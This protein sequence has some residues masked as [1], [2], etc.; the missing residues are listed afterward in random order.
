MKVCFLCGD[1]SRGGGTDRIAGLISG[2][3]AKKQEYEVFLVDVANK[4]GEVYFDISP[5]VNVVH[6][7]GYKRLDLI[8]KVFSLYKFLKKEKIDIVVNVDI[9]LFVYS[10]IPSIFCGVKIVSWEQFNYYNDIGSRHTRYIRQLCLKYTDYYVNLTSQDMETFKRNFKVKAPITYIYN[11]VS[12]CSESEYN[13]N[14]KTIITAGNFYKSKGYDH[15]V[16][17][18]EAVFKKHPD[19]KWLFCG[20]GEEYERIIEQVARTDCSENFVFAGRVRNLDE[21]MKASAIYVSCSLCE[22]FGL[23]LLEAQQNKLPV[24]SFDVPFGPSEII[25]DNINGFL[26]KDCNEKEM[27]EK[28]CELIESS[29]LRAKFSDNSHCQLHKFEINDIIKKWEYVLKSVMSMKG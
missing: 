12:Q 25:L 24:V 27:S 21:L 18:G 23:V 17:V 6:L 19:W 15:C 26:I 8:C 13:I 10:I 2:K 7:R 9:M 16:R 14:S 5:E 1:L 11:P 3:L 4:T 29:E 20:D 28:I 22:G